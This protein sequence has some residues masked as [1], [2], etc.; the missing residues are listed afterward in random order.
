MTG[1]IDD[2]VVQILEIVWINILL[3]GD[4]AVVIALA[5]R[6]LPP[7][8][9]RIGALL[10]A[11]AAIALRILFTLLIV[12]LLGIPVVKLAGAIL[13]IVIA[14]NLVTEDHSQQNVPTRA[15]IWGAVLTITLADAI[16][17]LDNVLAIA[18][19][20]RG[21]LLL[22]VFGLLISIPLVVFGAGLVMRLIT[23]FPVIAWAG[24]AL[25]GWVAGHMMTEDP[26]FA[27][28]LDRV[29]DPPDIVANFGGAIFVLVAGLL[30][31]WR[32]VAR[33]L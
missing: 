32:K 8:K 24:A 19:A 30:V 10:G 27:G 13:L 6:G 25:L 17:S 22:I 14:I 4:N 11:A 16:M 33:G 2:L 26:V 29:G 15:T 7:D 20:A 5:C 21:N 1:T 28:W 31:R 3:S 23:R 18:G 12:Q 9:Q